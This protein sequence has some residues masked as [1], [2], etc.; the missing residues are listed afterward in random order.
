MDKN[1]PKISVV[2]PVYNSE[3]YASEAIE[4]ILN[5]TE[6]DF[7]FII[8]DDGSTDNSEKIIKSFH[9]Q[10]IKYFKKPHSGIIDSL[11]FGIK[12]AR[13]EF[14]AR[15]DS[16]D[17]SIPERL[18]KQI[19]FFKN[20]PDYALVGS[21]AIKIDE[22]GEESGNLDYPPV[23]WKEIK[24]YSLLH[25]P[26]IHPTVM[27]KKELILTVGGYRNFK[28]AED[29]ELWTRIIYKYPCANIAE[30]LLKYR[31][32]SKQITEKRK[33]TSL[34]VRFFALFRFIF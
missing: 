22:F 12:E 6:K 19:L 21:C 20:N 18:E 29:Y 34:F 33:V 15:M 7:E 3:E 8:I 31:I 14:I 27:F 9:D 2:M 4:S 17:I 23:S 13:S 28:H 26:F 16:D 32:H 1:T 5:Q 30:P 25:N 10:R 24:K 11:N